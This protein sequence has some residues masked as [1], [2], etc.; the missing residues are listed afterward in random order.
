MV[1]D[2]GL[3][4][5]PPALRAVYVTVNAAAREQG[6][7][8]HKNWH[9]PD[10]S[11]IARVFES[12][13]YAASLEDLSWWATSGGSHLA[14]CPVTVKAKKHCDTVVALLIPQF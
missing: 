13:G 7:N 2:M 11:V 4:D 1:M 9:V 6:V 10:E 3:G 12:G 14:V 8:F 5:P